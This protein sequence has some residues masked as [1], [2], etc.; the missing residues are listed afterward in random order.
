MG[1]LFKT[2]LFPPPPPAVQV[3]V[4]LSD[5]ESRIE[6]LKVAEA[7]RARGIGADV[8]HQAQGFGKQMKA[9]ERRGIPYVWFVESGLKGEV[10]HL[11]TGEQIAAD[12]SVWQ[13]MIDKVAPEEASKQ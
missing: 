5:T 4:V 8:Y 13:P 7:L 1:Y 6:A 12:A 2:E 9:A 11:A 10:K 3:M